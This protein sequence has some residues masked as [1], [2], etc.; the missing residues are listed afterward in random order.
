MFVIYY[1]VLYKNRER[2]QYFGQVFLLFREMFL[3]R[4][5]I[6]EVFKKGRLIEGC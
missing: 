3:D 2:I 5:Y 4:C 6:R 1:F